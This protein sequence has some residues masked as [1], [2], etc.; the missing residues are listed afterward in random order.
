M[1]EILNDERRLNV[2]ITRACHKLI[3]VG[4]VSGLRCYAPLDRLLSQILAPSQVSSVLLDVD[5]VVVVVAV[6]LV[7]VVVVYFPVDSTSF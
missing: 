6:V 7:V 3:F 1:G 5:A 4:S 2:A